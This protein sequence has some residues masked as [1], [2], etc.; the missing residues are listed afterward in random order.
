MVSPELLSKYPFYTFRDDIYSEFMIKIFNCLEYR[1]FAS[2]FVIANELEECSDV[3]YINRALTTSAT[4][5]IRK[6]TLESNSE[7]IVSLVAIKF[8]IISDINL[9]IKLSS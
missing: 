7:K 2:N 6:F 1:Q 5:S 9:F 4:K 3:L 8:V